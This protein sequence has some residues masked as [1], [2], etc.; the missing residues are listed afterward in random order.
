VE[1]T[2]YTSSPDAIRTLEIRQPARLIV[3]CD[4]RR[5][6]DTCFY[7]SA[8]PDDEGAAR[9]LGRGNFMFADQHGEQF[10]PEEIWANDALF[11]N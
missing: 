6:N 3:L 1:L 4:E 9:H 8:N 5:P 11:N 10:R 2:R 7:W